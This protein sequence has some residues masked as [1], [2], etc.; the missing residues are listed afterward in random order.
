MCVVKLLATG[1]SFPISVDQAERYL[2]S[3]ETA[4][5]LRRFERYIRST[6]SLLDS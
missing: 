1:A 3:R 2:S 4:V 5:N 6:F